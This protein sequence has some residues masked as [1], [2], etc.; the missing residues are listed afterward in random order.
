VLIKLFVECMTDS[1]IDEPELKAN[2]VSTGEACI[3]SEGLL[4]LTSK[5]SASSAKPY[6]GSTRTTRSR[7]SASVTV[8]ARPL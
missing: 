1:S 4:T 2:V 5:P 3:T 8:R 7:A 6:R